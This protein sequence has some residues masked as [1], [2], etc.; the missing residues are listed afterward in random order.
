M[1]SQLKSVFQSIARPKAST[2]FVPSENAVP[3]DLIQA[4]KANVLKS[5]WSGKESY[6]DEISCG[7]DLFNSSRPV[8]FVYAFVMNMVTLFVSSPEPVFV[9]SVLFAFLAFFGGFYLYSDLKIREWEKQFGLKRAVWMPII[10]KALP[11]HRSMEFKKR[12]SHCVDRGYSI[13]AVI[14]Q[15]ET[16]GYLTEKVEE[17][18]EQIEAIGNEE[19]CVRLEDLGSLRGLKNQF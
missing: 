5:Q 7:V 18:L 2:S 19:M 11:D 3:L 14:D 17:A 9:G 8:F 16:E 15:I 10:K 6:V 4:F 12:L 13:D 1:F